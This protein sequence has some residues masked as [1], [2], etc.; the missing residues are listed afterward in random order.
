MEKLS[1]IQAI[2]STETENK[3]PIFYPELL[4]K[5]KERTIIGQLLQQQPPRWSTGQELSDQEHCELYTINS[6]IIPEPYTGLKQDLTENPI[7]DADNFGHLELT[8]RVGKEIMADKERNGFNFPDGDKYFQHLNL[9]NLLHDLQEAYVG[10]KLKK[11]LE[12]KLKEHELFD[13]EVRE[14]LRYILPLK[15]FDDNF[16]EIF[17]ILFAEKKLDKLG[18]INEDLIRRFDVGD[19][20]ARTTDKYR[21]LNE[22]YETIHRV[23]FMMAVLSNKDTSDA[24]LGLKYDV[25]QNTF[26]DLHNSAYKSEFIRLFI[27]HNESQ[28]RECINLGFSGRVKLWLLKNNRPFKEPSTILN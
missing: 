12:F 4:S 8:Y 11:D 3:Q 5:I 27:N 23:T 26:K 20:V 1:Y 24:S 18:V 2:P 22:L 14:Q 19:I 25:M 9:A 15:D 16:T 7:S 21:D 13:G 6:D 17:R 28:I 10:D